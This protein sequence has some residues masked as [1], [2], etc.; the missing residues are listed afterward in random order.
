MQ[1]E[2]YHGH[3]NISVLI[4][5]TEPHI[6]EAFEVLLLY[7]VPEAQ[8]LWLLLSIFPTFSSLVYIYK[9]LSSED[10]ESDL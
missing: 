7:S 6:W 10:L 1:A 5:G 4:S 8:H 3:V 2:V 9:V